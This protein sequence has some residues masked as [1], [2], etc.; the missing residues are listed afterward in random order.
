MATPEKSLIDLLYLYPFYN[1]E[2][3]LQELRLD[4]V[5]LDETISTERFLSY[6]DQ[7][8]SKA[9]EKRAKL[10]LQVYALD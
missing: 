2:N 1:N 6:V 9:L 5:I 10:L 7:T 4:E 8:K 3:E